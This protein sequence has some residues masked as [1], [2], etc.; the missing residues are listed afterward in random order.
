M[1]P[2]NH[3]VS[4]AWQIVFTFLPI[5]NYWAFYRIRKLQRYL[6]YIFVPA[7]TLNIIVVAYLYDVSVRGVWSSESDMPIGGT[8]FY[9]SSILPFAPEIWRLLIATQVIAWGLQAF[10]IYLVI[11]WSR[12]HNKQFDQPSAQTQPL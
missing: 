2:A 8:L 5:I 10:S 4:V 6:L 1:M 12:Q 9:D 7:M 11:I 3:K